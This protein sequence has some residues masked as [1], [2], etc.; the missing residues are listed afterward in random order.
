MSDE[1]TAY[2]QWFRQAEFRD[3]TDLLDPKND[4]REDR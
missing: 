4:E 2:E 3:V 1:Q